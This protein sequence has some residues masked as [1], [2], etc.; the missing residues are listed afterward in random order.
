[1]TEK[2][3]Y[4]GAFLD[5]YFFDKK[6]EFGMQYYSILNNKIM[7]EFKILGKIDLDV[8]DKRNI[9]QEIFDEMEE[10]YFPRLMVTNKCCKKNVP[11]FGAM[12]AKNAPI[13]N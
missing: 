8:F 3:K 7:S 5:G 1:M 11:V 10:D 6:V 4:I 12:R 13:F 9:E 2:Q